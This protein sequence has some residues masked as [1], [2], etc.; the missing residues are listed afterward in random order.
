M[1]DNT[2]LK[3][4]AIGGDGTGP[5]VNAEALK[6]LAAVAKLEGFSFEVKEFDY[7]GDRYLATGEVLPEGAVEELKQFDAIMLGAD[8]AFRQRQRR[9]HAFAR[10][11]HGPGPERHRPFLRREHGPFQ[12][13]TA[14]QGAS[15]DPVDVVPGVTT[16]A[17]RAVRSRSWARAQMSG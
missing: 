4:A 7:G 1:S 15:A 5:E 3:I 9:A 12:L 14:A 2:P 16:S 13:E 10:Q 6:V 11:P 17:D 8:F